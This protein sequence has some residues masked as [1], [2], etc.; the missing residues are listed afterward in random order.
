MLV[1]DCLEILEMGGAALRIDELVRDVLDF[2]V[3]CA[4][5]AANT[6]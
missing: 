2:E 1:L 5:F 4:G 3:V 6:I